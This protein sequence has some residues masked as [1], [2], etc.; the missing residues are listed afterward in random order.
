M[1]VVVQSRNPT[2]GRRSGHSLAR[3]P[4]IQSTPSGP[5][6]VFKLARPEAPEEGGK[7]DTSES[8]CDRYKPCE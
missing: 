4:V 2:I 8:K 6:E 3:W 1:P 5:L 7:A